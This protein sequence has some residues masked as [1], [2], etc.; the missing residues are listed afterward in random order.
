LTV[1]CCIVGCQPDYITI[2]ARIEG[3]QRES[4]GEK[5]TARVFGRLLPFFADPLSAACF[6]D[7]H[8]AGKPECKIECI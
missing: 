5:K 2:N 3:L 8:R 6:R 1:H 7:A 4:I